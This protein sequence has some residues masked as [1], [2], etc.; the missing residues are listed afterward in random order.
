ML[1]VDRQKSFSEFTGEIAKDFYIETKADVESIYD[2]IDAETKRTASKEYF[3]TSLI[4]LAFFFLIIPLIIFLVRYSILKNSRN[5]IVTTINSKLDQ[6]RIYHY[7][8]K[9]LH[10]S[11]NLTEIKTSKYYNELIYQNAFQYNLI[12]DRAT[13]IYNSPLFYF[14]HPNYDL[15]FEI[16]K[17]RWY[18]KVNKNQNKPVYEDVG[19]ITFDLKHP[20]FTNFN[21]TWLT[22]DNHLGLNKVKLENKLFNK[23]FMMKTD[24]EVKARMI[25]TP[26]TMEELLRHQEENIN[27]NKFIVQK[28]GNRITIC[29]LPYEINALELDFNFNANVS[30]MVKQIVNDFARDVYQIYA[31]FALV[32][33]PPFINWEN[34]VW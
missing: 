13:P 25:A 27:S 28:I 29:F 24:D 5:L 21:F 14:N 20:K 1:R 22:N 31:L 10:S 26:L 7:L 9:S 8:F 12:P 19:L 15:E 33:I 4:F 6:F 16:N 11:L 30:E 23:I 32:F 3:D 2:S 34:N 18:T 17:F